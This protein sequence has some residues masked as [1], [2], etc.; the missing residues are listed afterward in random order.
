[1][2]VK[3]TGRIGFIPNKSNRLC[4]KHFKS[5]D[6]H[7]NLGGNYRLILKNDAVPSIS[8]LSIPTK[9][10]CNGPPLKKNQTNNPA[11]ALFTTSNE[12]CE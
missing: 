9:L 2:W 7:D 4:Q 8:K 11:Q 12:T 10:F 6:F 3:A 1:L 5:S